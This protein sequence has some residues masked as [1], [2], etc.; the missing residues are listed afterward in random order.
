MKAFVQFANESRPGFA[1]PSG[2]LA[3][4]IYN[5]QEYKYSRS[6]VDREFVNIVFDPD[7]HADQRL[8]RS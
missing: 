6:A 2:V 8:L 3:R 1:A 5:I 7:H 4:C